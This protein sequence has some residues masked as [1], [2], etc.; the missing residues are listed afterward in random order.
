MFRVG[1]PTLVEDGDVAL[2]KI[3]ALQAEEGHVEA[4]V[5]SLLEDLVGVA[6]SHATENR[7]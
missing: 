7:K 3:E 2:E 5:G 6:R 4:E 1:I